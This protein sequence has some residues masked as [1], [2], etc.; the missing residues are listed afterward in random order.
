[1]SNNWSF[2]QVWNNALDKDRQREII[3]RDYTYASELGKGYY[4]RYWKMQGR[5][6]RT[7]PGVRAQ[8]KFEAGN[9]TEWVMQQVLS[10]AGVLQSI[11]ERLEDNDSPVRVSGRCDFLAGGQIQEI[12]LIELGLPETFADVAEIAIAKLKEKYPDGLREQ[13][14]EI[15]SCAG[16]MFDRYQKKP[17]VHHALQSY[18]YASQTGK[19]YTLVY[20]S[21]D[22]LRVCEWTIMPSSESWGKLYQADLEGLAEF[23]K[24]DPKDVRKNHKE[25][26]LTWDP[27]SGRFSKN[28]EVEYSAYLTD[29][30]FKRPD[31]Y[32]T[33]ASSSATRLNNIVK[34]I[35][36]GK[37]MTKVNLAS[38]EF[39]YNFYPGAE[40]I[41]N[42]QKEQYGL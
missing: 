11:Q 23:L 12:D 37:E 35:R 14:L 8:R 42:Q 7:P 28:W 32:K 2:A 24:L 13:G 10:R 26:L 36:A 19:P 4:D 15:K 16:T 41:I 1:M 18:F 29:Y 33:P 25:P 17:S 38:L 9:L 6:P 34:K 21:R 22:D 3:P 27:E 30:G 40:E 5:K 39:C 20:V 31:L